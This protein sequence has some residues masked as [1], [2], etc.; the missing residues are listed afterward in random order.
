[1]GISKIVQYD[2][3]AMDIHC[4]LFLIIDR[5]GISKIVQ[6]DSNALSENEVMQMA[7]ESGPNHSL[8]YET[9]LFSSTSI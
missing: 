9:S 8:L 1:V 4:R 5:G 3:N 7:N 6:Y 2:S